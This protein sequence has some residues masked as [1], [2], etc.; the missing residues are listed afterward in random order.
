MKY[1]TEKT[2]PAQK[3]LSEQGGTISTDLEAITY[4]FAIYG[5]FI[6]A[7]RYGNGHINDTY[8]VAFY[9]AG[10]RVRYILQRINHR[11]FRDVPALMANVRRVCDHTSNLVRRNKSAEA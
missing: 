11:V 9:Q 1:P 8:L 6:R 2:M 4:L 10:T 3:P 7:D 5:D